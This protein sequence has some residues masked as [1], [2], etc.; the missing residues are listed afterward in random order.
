MEKTEVAYFIGIVFSILTFSFTVTSLYK[1]GTDLKPNLQ[2]LVTVILAYCG[3]LFKIP[4]SFGSGTTRERVFFLC[5][6][7]LEWMAIML[8]IWGFRG[9]TSWSYPLLGLVFAIGLPV[10]LYCLSAMLR[11]LRPKKSIRSQV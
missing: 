2:L 6:S 7:T 9:V 8:G 5:T 10:F 1:D 3:S 4:K 11:P